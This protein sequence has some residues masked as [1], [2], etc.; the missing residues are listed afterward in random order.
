MLMVMSML[1]TGSMIN[2]KDT[3]NITTKMEHLIKGSGATTN[4]MDTVLR[5]GLME[6]STKENMLQVRSM[7][8]VSFIGQT[9]LD[10]MVIFC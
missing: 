3:V 10:I 6:Q 8:K 9:I 5:F 1:E 2:H 7:E 4:N